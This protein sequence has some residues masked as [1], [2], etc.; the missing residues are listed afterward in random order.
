[1]YSIYFKTWIDLQDKETKKIIKYIAKRNVAYCN[2][3]DGFV[4]YVREKRG[5]K[6]NEKL[7]WKVGMDNGQGSFKIV[8]SLMKENNSE[9]NYSKKVNPI[10]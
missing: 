5:I 9:A 7:N 4:N 1:M 2:D 3:L 6:E 10:P 8:L